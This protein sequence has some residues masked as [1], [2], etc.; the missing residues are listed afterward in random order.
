MELHLAGN[1]G[2]ALVYW[3][4]TACHELGHNIVRD[5]SS[6]HSFYTESFVQMY[7]G[8]CMERVMGLGGVGGQG[9]GVAGRLAIE[10]VAAPP[11]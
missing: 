4:V 6:D 5:H 10:G 8:R 7:F 11:L 9:V 1:K 3:F 2:E